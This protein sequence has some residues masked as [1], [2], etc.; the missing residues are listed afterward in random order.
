MFQHS[1]LAQEPQEDIRKSE[2]AR[3]VEYR[4]HT[5]ILSLTGEKYFLGDRHQC[6][7]PINSGNVGLDSHQFN[8][9]QSHTLASF[10]SKS[11]LLEYFWHT[12]YIWL[13]ISIWGYSP[14]P[15]L[16]LLHSKT[17]RKKNFSS[18]Q[19]QTNLAKNEYLLW[20]RAIALTFVKW[21]TELTYAYQVYFLTFVSASQNGFS[22]HQKAP[23]MYHKNQ[24][25]K[26]S[27]SLW[28]WCQNL[29]WDRLMRIVS[30]KTG[31][32]LTEQF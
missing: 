11:V 6:P 18:P 31:P 32:N 2:K 17:S 13:F 22:N 8:W 9:M 25:S 24:V 10:R 14:F 12:D 29:N 7:N 28:S 23:I 1:W 21:W 30:G 5:C 16:L 20:S 27:N 4:G 3:Y 15:V 26:S 19:L